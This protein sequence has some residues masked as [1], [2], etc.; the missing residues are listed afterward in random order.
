MDHSKRFVCQ[1]MNVFYPIG[2]YKHCPEDMGI[3]WNY[4][5][6]NAILRELS[7]IAPLNTY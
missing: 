7:F 1:K 5:G 2:V 4:V 3:N 6:H